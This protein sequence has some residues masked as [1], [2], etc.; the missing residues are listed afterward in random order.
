MA[1]RLE[2]DKI[3]LDE[4][5]W[6]KPEVVNFRDAALAWAKANGIL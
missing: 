6:W 1:R 5:T 4:I 2:P 3:G